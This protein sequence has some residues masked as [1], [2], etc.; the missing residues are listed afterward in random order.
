MLK[1]GKLNWELMSNI[2]SVLPVNDIDVIMGPA[3]G[4][5]AAVIRVRDG[6]LVVHS[7]P[8]TT[9]VR[10]AGYLSVHVAGNDIAVRGVKPKWFLPV[11]LLPSW[12]SEA[13]IM[14]FFNDM[15]RALKEVEGVVIGG[16]TEITPSISRPIV[17]MTAAGY[18]TSRIIFTRDAKVGDLVYVIGRIGG[19]GVGV[20]AW[21]FETVLI[22]KNTSREVIEKAKTYIYDVSVIKTALEIKDYVNA[23]HDATE[24]GVL[25]ALREIAIA[26]NTKII[27]H[28]ENLSLDETVEV[29][30]KTVNVDPLKLL[31]SGCIVATVPKSN[32]KEFESALENLGKPYSLIGQVEYGCGEVV[33]KSGTI[34]ELIKED[35]IDEIYKLWS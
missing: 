5:D 30:A 11:V 18:T 27:V 16:H 17:S 25:Q 3:I 9:G 23:M 15:S 34:V 13:E 19:E 24:G 21:D 1:T 2:L 4:E 35:I 31:S 26:S 20:I 12:F 6:F 22:E 7:D 14:E 33:V 28:R 8:I 29:I 10:R 32:K